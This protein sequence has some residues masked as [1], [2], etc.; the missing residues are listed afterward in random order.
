MCCF[1]RSNTE[2]IHANRQHEQR[3]T[4][5]RDTWLC[6]LCQWR[7]HWYRH[8]QWRFGHAGW[9]R[10]SNQR[11]PT[12]LLFAGAA[13]QLC[14]LQVQ[15]LLKTPAPLA[16]QGENA[17]SLG[18][19]GSSNTYAFVLATASFRFCCNCFIFLFLQVLQRFHFKAIVRAFELVSVLFW[20]TQ[21]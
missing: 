20:W 19:L 3:H 7:Q 4:Q 21:L 6:R 1:L 15:L 10:W 12:R 9:S 8:L 13:L 11:F 14:F 18:D 5:A 2:I 17:S 16:I